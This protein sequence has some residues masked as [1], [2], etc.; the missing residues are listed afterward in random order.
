VL[1]GMRGKHS[2]SRLARARICCELL[3]FWIRQLI[4]SY[5]S[6]RHLMPGRVQISSPMIAYRFLSTFA[7]EGT[8]T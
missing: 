2:I 3:N 6:Y 5:I 8:T 1:N 4:N 7:F